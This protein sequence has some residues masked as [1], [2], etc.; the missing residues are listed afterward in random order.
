MKYAV[1]YESA[2]GN[3]KML[4]D[5]IRNVLGG[6]DCI[7]FGTPEE[8]MQSITEEAELLF[9]GFWT[10]KGEC[11]EKIRTYMGTLCNRKVF[12]FGTAGFG[13]SEQYFS[14]ILSRVSAHLPEGNAV[15]GTYMCQGKM[16]QS[17]RRRYETMQEKAPQ[18]DQIKMMIENFDRAL[19]HPDQNDLIHLR[20]TITSLSI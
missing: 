8:N 4:A 13:G 16:P 18:D 5:E 11:G 14:Q 3:T 1:I 7:F 2:T 17:V 12:L 10:D 9:L 6:Q 19:L 20:E 15:V